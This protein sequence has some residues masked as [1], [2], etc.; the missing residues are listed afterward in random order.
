MVIEGIVPIAAAV[1]AVSAAF[2][3]AI[4][5]VSTVTYLYNVHA[6]FEYLRARHPR[7]WKA[8]GEPHLFWNNSIRTNGALAAVLGSNVG[9]DISDQD[10]ARMLRK[11]KQLYSVS[12]IS[13][14][15]CLICV[16]VYSVFRNL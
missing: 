10:V 12:S 5:A 7:A 3:F 6:L 8:L 15:L 13:F 14:T 2:T 16:L 1:L 9:E 11:V 4:L